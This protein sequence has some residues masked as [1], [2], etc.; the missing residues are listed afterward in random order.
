[1]TDIQI[2][3]IA[4][5]ERAF[6]GP[7]LTDG[8]RKMDMVDASNIVNDGSVIP[9]AA[10]VIKSSAYELHTLKV[11]GVKGN[12]SVWLTDVEGNVVIVDS[13]HAS[14]MTL[15]EAYTFNES[16]CVKVLK[17]YVTTLEESEM[18]HLKSGPTIKRPFWMFWK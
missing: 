4:L 13:R 7:V 10:K 6:N 3:L 18:A 9:N 12:L 15:Q 16:V 8:V 17:S 14:D 11:T 5:I 1:M 2:N